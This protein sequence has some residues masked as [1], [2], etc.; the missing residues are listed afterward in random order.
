[1]LTSAE[2]A[3][4][5]QQ[6]EAIAAKIDKIA[7]AVPQDKVTYGDVEAALSELHQLGFFPDNLLVS[8]TARAFAQANKLSE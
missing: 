7:A 3:A 5:Q 6:I 2:T 8:N 1:M 4:R